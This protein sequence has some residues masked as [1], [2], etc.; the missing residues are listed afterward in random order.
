MAANWMKAR[1]TRYAAY[2]TVYILVIIAVIVAANFLANRYDKT[3][4]AT[5]NKR[6]SLSEQTTKIVK[7]LKEPIT[8][9]Y[10]DKASNFQTGKDLLDQY[11]NL[12][13]NVHVEFVDPYKKPQLARQAGIKNVGTATIDYGTKHE[14]ARTFDEEGIT[15]AIVRAE[16]G[17]T[18]NV[19][20]VQGNGEHSLDETGPDGMSQAKDL[21]Q[22]D[23][24]TSKTVN[25]LQKAQVPT[26]CSVLV[27]AGPTTD[28]AQPEV[29]AIRNYVQDGGRALFMLDP[30]LKVQGHPVADNAPLAALLTSWGVTPE[31]DLVLDE[32]PIGQLAG[33]GPEVPLVTSYES[34]PI[35]QPMKGLATG[36]PLARSLQ[37]KNGD[38]TSVEKLFSTSP[39]SVATTNLSAR[40]I[41]ITN[42]DKKGPFTLAAAG[43]YTTGKP[44]SEGRF[45]VVGNSTWASNRFVK[46]NGN[47]DLL[48][49]MINWLSSDTDLISIRPKQQED[50]RVTMNRAQMLWMRT[51]CQFILPGIVVI[52]GVMV[53][54]KRR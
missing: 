34:H 10:W 13:N 9:T 37:T 39:D 45:V 1:Q 25:L 22:G 54:L 42:T 2:A 51:F 50:R 15:G 46:F 6:Y 48:L 47:R 26:D 17:G 43:T 3:Y 38:K 4:D 49:N 32:N 11:R 35:V 8:I 44:N 21:L 23:N 33:L 52:A 16:K 40:E 29:D 28:F 18:K 27:V 30:P 24:Y 36:F 41:Q 19:C 7:N 14:E 53:W 12:S 20:F 31:N 5:A